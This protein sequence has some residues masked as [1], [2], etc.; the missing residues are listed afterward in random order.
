MTLSDSDIISCIALFNKYSNSAVP[1]YTAPLSD[2]DKQEIVD[3]VYEAYAR[4]TTDDSKNNRLEAD[5]KHKDRRLNFVKTIYKVFCDILPHPTLPEDPQVPTIPPDPP[6]EVE[7]TGYGALYNRSAVGKIAEENVYGALYNWYAATKRASINFNKENYGVL[8]NWYAVTYNTGGAS[9]APTGWHIPT[10]AEFQTLINTID[11][12]NLNVAGDHLKEVGALHW[13][14]VNPNTEADNSS[15]FT[16]VGSGLRSGYVGTEG[17]F[18]ALGEY[19]ILWSPEIT[20][21]PL[22]DTYTG[23]GLILFN[24]NS[25]GYLASA[26]GLTLPEVKSMGYAIRLIKDDSTD[27][28]TMTDYDENIYSTVKIGT[29]VWMAKNLMVEHYNDG[30]EIPLITDNTL[31]GEDTAGAMCYYDN[32]TE[33]EVGDPLLPPTGW[34]VP[35]NTEWSTLITYLGGL[36]VA[37]GKMK[38]EGTVHW[39]AINYADNSSG[40]TAF[41]SGYRGNDN[42]GVFNGNLVVTNFGSSTEYSGIPTRTYGRLVSNPSLECFVTSYLKTS[43]FSIRCILDGV[44]PDD[45]GSVTDIDGNVYPTVKIGTQVWMAENL[46]VEQYNDGTSIPIITDDTLWT[47]D[48]AGAMCYY[49]NDQYT[50]SFNIFPIDGWHVAT[51]QEWTDLTSF[52][53]FSVCGIK[54]K[55]AGTSHWA[56][57]YATNESG[58]TL[59]PGGF[60]QPTG[61]YNFLGYNAYII[62]VTDVDSQ[63]FRFDNDYDSTRVFDTDDHSGYS[64]RLVKDTTTLSEGETSTVLDIDGNLYPTI[65]ING[66]EWL[67][68]NYRCTSYN[69]DTD[70]PIIIDATAWSTDTAGAMCYY[71]NIPQDPQT[72]IPQYYIMTDG[73]VV[74]RKGVRGGAFVIDIALTALAFGGVYGTDWVNLQTAI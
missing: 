27:P 30:T 9:I 11:P 59:L 16:A 73:T 50:D 21:D 67:T 47:E 3:Y 5:K 57:G 44:D 51:T 45:P 61:Q 2:E 28:G 17:M 49:N 20:Y 62:S 56:S 10:Q 65:C 41:G 18:V 19:G 31:W 15:G 13:F 29:Q 32:D 33:T 66:H 70:I 42:L 55:E 37:G 24:Y 6:E 52:L 8:Y 22:N 69:N 63:Y 53:V 4:Y 40:F 38:E 39:N 72:N 23:G 7:V 14:G 71:N 54:L 68:V 34:H 46:K 64:V 35:T 36:S 43:G 60:R 12:E 74:Y 25:G 1:S 48:T 58:L 26:G